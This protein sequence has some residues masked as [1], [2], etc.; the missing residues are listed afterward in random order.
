MCAHTHAKSTGH[1]TLIWR[2]LQ[3]ILLYNLVFIYS[4]VEFTQTHDHW[5]D[6]SW[7]SN[8]LILCCPVLLLPSIFPSIRV[9]SNESAPCIRWPKTGASASVLPVNV[10]GWYPLGLTVLI[11]LL[12]KGLSRVF[13]STTLWK[14]QFFDSQV[15][16][17]SNSH[18]HTWLLL[19]SKFAGILSV[20]L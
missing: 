6:D 15:S 3:Y 1:Y 10:Q 12:S 16:F 20:A 14:H 18:I 5:V 9:F 19:F 2:V 17:W 4:T 7:P 8:D 11:S 13:S